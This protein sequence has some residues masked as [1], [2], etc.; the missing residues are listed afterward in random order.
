MHELIFFLENVGELRFFPLRR[1]T[2]WTRTLTNTH[3]TPTQK[4]KQK[5]SSTKTS[6]YFAKGCTADKH[7]P[8]KP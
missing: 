1:R 3:N 7:D 2:E 6:L 8:T 5:H 4:T